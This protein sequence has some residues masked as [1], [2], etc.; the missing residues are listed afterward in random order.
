MLQFLVLL[1]LFLFI[2][3]S[4]FTGLLLQALFFWAASF[5]RFPMKGI[6]EYVTVFI[7]A[8]AHGWAWYTLVPEPFTAV[9]TS[10]IGF[11]SVV[12]FRLSLPS[13]DQVE[14]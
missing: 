14:S 9:M 7:L 6:V 10:V 2:V 1:Y 8:A 13:G 12:Y 5:S 3:G 11:I 4:A